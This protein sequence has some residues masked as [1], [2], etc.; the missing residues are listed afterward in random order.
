[1]NAVFALVERDGNAR[2][3]HVPNVE[4]D[5]LRKILAIHADRKSD[6]MTDEAPVFMGIG[7]NFASHGSVKHS[8]DEYVRGN[9]HPNTIENY[10]SLVK[11]QLHGTYISVEPFHLFRYLDE[12]SFRYNTRKATDAE[13]FAHCLLASSWSSSDVG[14]PDR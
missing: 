4:G 7:W 12:Q 3:F 9:V 2:A 5:N 11:R 8:A 10:W 6:F 1:M 13:R 14:S